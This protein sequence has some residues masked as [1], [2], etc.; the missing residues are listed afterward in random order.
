MQGWVQIATFN[1]P[2]LSSSSPVTQDTLPNTEAD[3][4]PNV[5]VDFVLISRRSRD[6]AGLR[7]QRRGIDDEGNVANFVET[8]QIVRCSS[9]GRAFSFIQI[10]GS[11]KSV[12]FDGSSFLVT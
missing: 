8:E 12:V 7:F 5:P 4:L 10:R 6:R 1:V 11:S 9:K 2:P 3:P